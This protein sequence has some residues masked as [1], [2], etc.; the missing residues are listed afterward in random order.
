MN[1]NTKTAYLTSLGHFIE[2]V[3]NLEKLDPYKFENFLRIYENQD[4][5]YFYN[6]LSTSINIDQELTPAAYY[7]ISV[8]SSVPW[9]TL[10][11]N[12][13]RTIHLWWLIMEVNNIKN[14][15]DY[16]TPGTKLRILFPQYAKYVLDKIAEKVKK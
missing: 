9:T 3:E 4:G 13:Y 16:P 7:E 11:Y 8:R 6:L 14:P 2:N 5:Q 12:E 15:L 10:S 1:L